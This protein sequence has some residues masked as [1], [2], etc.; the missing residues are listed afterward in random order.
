M[1]DQNKDDDLGHTGADGPAPDGSNEKF[2]ESDSDFASSCSDSSFISS[3]EQ[4]DNFQQH[5]QQQD[6]T[7]IDFEVAGHNL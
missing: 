3:E 4:K 2:D 5:E 7:D 6:G 1:E